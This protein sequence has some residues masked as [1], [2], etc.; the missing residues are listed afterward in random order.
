MGGGV[1]FFPT[2]VTVVVTTSDAA[3]AG[4][5]DSEPYARRQAEICKIGCRN[6]IWNFIFK[7]SLSSVF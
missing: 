5:A 6:F 1:P 2:A 4:M 7:S 3:R